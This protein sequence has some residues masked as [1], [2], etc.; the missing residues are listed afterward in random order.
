MSAVSPGAFWIFSLRYLPSPSCVMPRW[1]GTSSLG[2][3]ANLIV[4]FWPGPDRLGQVLADL[5]GIDVEGGREL[6]VADVVA[7][8]V[9]VHQAGHAL[10]RV[11]V[12]VVLDALHEGGG[13]VAHAHDRDAHLLRS[14]SAMRRC[15]KSFQSQSPPEMIRM[16]TAPAGADTG[17]YEN[18]RGGFG[19]TRSRYLGELASHVQYPLERR[20]NRQRGH[21]VDGRLE[22]LE[23]CPGRR[24][25]RRR[26]RSRG[27]R[28]ARRV[29]R[30][31]PCTP[32]PAPRRA[33]ACS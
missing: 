3:S 27:S 23:V 31:R 26:A 11:G 32:P 25:W 9:D 30:R 20:E 16:R 14:G 5:V 21:H 4:L 6:D 33:R 8:E 10:V 22:Q 17:L 15:P 7:A 29:R 2:T 28:R 12:L 13:A 1:T 18:R 19:Y 24:P